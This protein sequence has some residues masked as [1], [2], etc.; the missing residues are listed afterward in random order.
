M[1]TVLR[2]SLKDECILNSSTQA[3]PTDPSPT[4]TLQPSSSS[5]SSSSRPS[6]YGTPIEQFLNDDTVSPT[7]LPPSSS[8]LSSAPSETNPSYIPTMSQGTTSSPLDSTNAGQSIGATGTST[9]ANTGAP[10][11]VSLR[12]IRGRCEDTIRCY[13]C[14]LNCF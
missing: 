12:L 13:Q 11:N 4:L 1:P 6:L 2:G 7:S 14:L 9:P 10:T 8:S 5:S 3:T